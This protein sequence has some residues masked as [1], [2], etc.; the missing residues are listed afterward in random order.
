MKKRFIP[1][2][3]LSICAVFFASSCKEEKK[4]QDIITKKVMKKKAS[5]GTQKMSEFTWS[6]VIDWAGGSY[7]ISIHRVADTSLPMAKDESGN[8]YYDNRITLKI[9]RADGSVFL[10]HTFTKDDFL[11][12][13]D[14]KYGKE[15]ALLGL[16]LDHAGKNSIYFGASIG[17]P[18]TMSDEYIPLTVTVSKTGDIKIIKDTQMDTNSAD[19]PHNEI[20][21][22]EAEG[23]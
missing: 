22:A 21:A 6:K 4:S 17:S 5:L 7:T 16:A 14:N 20:E 10:D 3:L 12:F 15:G 11:K 23:M 2:L 8:S 13:T 19:L 9:T 1:V 18:D